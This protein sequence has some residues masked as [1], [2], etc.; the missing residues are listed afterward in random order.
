MFVKFNPTLGTTNNQLR[1]FNFMRIITAI[2][3]AAAGSTPV[4]RPMTAQNTFDENINLITEIISNAEAGSWQTSPK[5]DAQNA[6][7]GHNLDETGYT[8]ANF[9]NRLY[10]ADFWRD[11]GK[12]QLPYLKFTVL[13]QIFST[14]T[15]FPY[16]DIIHGAHTDKQYDNVTGYVPTVDVGNGGGYGYASVNLTGVYHDGTRAPWHSIRPA[17]TGPGA[18]PWGQSANV[19]RSDWWLAVT[20]GYFI[21]IQPYHAITYFGLRSTN[22]WEDSYDD[23]PPIAAFNTP[24][25]PWQRGY[26]TAASWPTFT[27]K[28]M[29]AWWRTKDGND[30]VRAQPLLSRRSNSVDSINPICQTYQYPEWISSDADSYNRIS[31]DGH[32]SPFFRLMATMN[33]AWRMRDQGA[34]DTTNLPTLGYRYW[35]TVDPNTGASV[36]CAVPIYMRLGVNTNDATIPARTWMNEGGKLP[37]I[38]KSLSG[39]DAYMLKYYTPGETLTVDGEPYYPIISGPDVRYRD[40]FLIRAR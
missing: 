28:K 27:S 4:V 16:M 5:F 14:W 32:G 2:A 35:A 10:R 29:W 26:T 6:I 11:S 7:K 39:S 38:Y 24:L 1:C 34:D 31:G 36:P 15:S 18:N 40:M 13:N 30:S 23:N 8:E 25:W 3:T 17:D 20:A 33:I 19:E 37:G 12:A 22:A 21:L 9:N